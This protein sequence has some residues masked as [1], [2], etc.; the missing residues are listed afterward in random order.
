MLTL[1]FKKYYNVL[2]SKLLPEKYV[3][4]MSDS[5]MNLLYLFCVK[6]SEKKLVEVWN[7]KKAASTKGTQGEETPVSSS[8]N[9]VR[10]S[11]LV[12][13]VFNYLF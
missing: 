5:K 12:A 4:T 10:A 13:F 2:E 3:A 7:H 9:V 6:V 11:S 1:C 8:G